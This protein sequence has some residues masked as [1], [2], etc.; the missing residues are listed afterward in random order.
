[1]QRKN[2]RNIALACFLTAAVTA[3][4]GVLSA[5]EEAAA[6]TEQEQQDTAEVKNWGGGYEDCT[7]RI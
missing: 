7:H 2:I 5:K 1:M 3:G 6:A 4:Q